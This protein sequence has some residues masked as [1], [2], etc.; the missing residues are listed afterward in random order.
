VGLAPDK[1]PHLIH[2]RSL[3]AADLY[4][5]RFGT[6]PF[7]DTLVDVLQGRGFFFNSSMTVFGL[8]RN[9]RA[10]SRTPL[11]LRVGGLH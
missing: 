1:T 7:N 6:A 10:I 9:T 5:A 8:I 11:P 3:H 4:R 2:L